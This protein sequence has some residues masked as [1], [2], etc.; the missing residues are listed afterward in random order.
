MTT[1]IVFVGRQGRLLRKLCILERLKSV[2]NDY[3]T[4]FQS[5]HQS[6]LCRVRVAGYKLRQV[7]VRFLLCNLTPSGACMGFPSLKRSVILL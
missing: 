7:V 3:R 6:V 1:T 2:R 4:L 5:C